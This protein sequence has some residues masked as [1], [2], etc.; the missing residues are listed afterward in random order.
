MFCSLDPSSSHGLPL[1]GPVVAVERR[2]MSLEGW[3][4]TVS[5]WQSR[6][7]GRSGEQALLLERLRSTVP[8]IDA[9]IDPTRPAVPL[10]ALTARA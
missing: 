10:Q 1:R 8:R 3:S 4:A 2:A 6:L 9:T 5:E 7:K